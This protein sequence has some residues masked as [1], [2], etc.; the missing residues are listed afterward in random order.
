MTPRRAEFILTKDQDRLALQ[1]P[2]TVKFVM[3]KE[4]YR[5]LELQRHLP[6]RAGPV[7]SKTPVS[8]DAET[9]QFGEQPWAGAVVS[10]P[11]QPAQCGITRCAARR[12]V[13]FDLS[14]EP[15]MHV[16]VPQAGSDKVGI[17]Q[18]RHPLRR[19]FPH[20]PLDSAKQ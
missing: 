4:F 17:G 3:P 18:P 9:I 7:S 15:L 6:G 2:F 11:S 1:K 16:F 20:Q 13:S 10:Y 8:T 19:S 14:T 12:G 5:S